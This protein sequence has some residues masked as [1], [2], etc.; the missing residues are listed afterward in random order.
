MAVQEAIARER[1]H[2][3][4]CENPQAYDPQANGGA[5]RA[6]AE[7]KA[8]M[9]AIKIGFAMRIKK[10]IDPRWAILE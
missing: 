5:E 4:V 7:V 10:T 2:D 1:T 6:V 9:K 3:T 8:Q